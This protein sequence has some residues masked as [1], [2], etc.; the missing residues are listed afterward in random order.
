MEPCVFFFKRKKSY[1][2]EKYLTT[3]REFNNKIWATKPRK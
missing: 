3:K 2:K 1:K